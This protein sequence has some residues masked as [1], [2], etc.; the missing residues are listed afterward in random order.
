VRSV[1]PSCWC[2]GARAGV[3]AGGSV[4]SSKC[5]F[6]RKISI[7]SMNIATRQGLPGV[8]TYGPDIDLDSD[9]LPPWSTAD[10]SPDRPDTFEVE[11]GP[12]K[13]CVV[14][15]DFDLFSFLISPRSFR[16]GV[17]VASRSD[18]FCF[19]PE[20][21]L[22]TDDVLARSTVGPTKRSPRSRRRR[23]RRRS[24]KGTF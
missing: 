2:V 6:E 19:F 23:R 17:V 14:I 9:A 5:E 12:F 7:S 11:P 15:S 21:V 13:L 4:L 20:N 8:L 3:G 18:P 10:T 16:L 24:I 1:G 22:K